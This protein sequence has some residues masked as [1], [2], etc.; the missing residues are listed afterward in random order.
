MRSL[1]AE[2]Q[3]EPELALASGEDG[4]DLTRAILA[5]SARTHLTRRTACWSSRSATTATARS[6][7]PGRLSP[8]STPAPA[9]STSSCCIATSCRERARAAAAPCSALVAAVTALCC[10]PPPC[11]W[12]AAGQRLRRDS[13]GTA[14]PAGSTVLAF[15]NS[16]TFGTGALPGEDYPSRAGSAQRLAGRQRRHPRRH[17]RGSPR[18][19]RGS[20]DGDQA[21][22]GDRRTRRQRLSPPAPGAAVKE[23]LRAIVSSH[24]ADSGAQVVLVAVPK[25]SLLGA[26]SGR[27]PDSKSTPSWPAKKSCRWST[28]V[29]AEVL[30]DPELK[31]D[32]I[33]PNADG[34]RQLAAGIA[35]Q[36][37]QAGLLK[38]P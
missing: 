34:Y 1:P 26:I 37:R 15:G 35:D 14:L 36:L 19:D 28:G 33:H 21:G 5:G 16:I 32:P 22:A 8:G 23:D 17:Q 2:Y 31:A 13:Q 24:S 6:R 18:A 27:L 30:A 25:L 10:W 7:F 11:C 38:A 9:I 20:P 4:L 29:L 12:P 3:R